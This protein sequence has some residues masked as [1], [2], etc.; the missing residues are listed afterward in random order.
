VL[1]EQ[2]R[3]R[4]RDRSRPL[5]AYAQ[6]VLDS[7]GLGFV[8]ELRTESIAGV[9]ERQLRGESCEALTE[10]A[11]LLI[12]VAADP[13]LAYEAPPPTHATPSSVVPAPLVPPA[14]SSPA[15]D[16]LPP[17]QTDDADLLPSPSAVE[18]APPPRSS[19]RAFV[20][21]ETTLQFFGLLPN[22][23]G[24]GFGGALGLLL[25]S[26][27]IELRGRYHLSSSAQ[28]PGHPEI[29][30]DF[31]QW[32]LGPSGCFE[33]AVG[34]VSFPLCGG[35]EVGATRGRSHGVTLDGRATSLF[36][37]LNADIAAVF[38]PIPQ[39]GFWLG[40]Q[41]VVA[42]SRPRFHIR[43]LDTLFRV[44]PGGL[45]LVAGIEVRFP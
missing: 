1:R 7:D 25:P 32:T 33:P 13:T 44:G 39:L 27:R 19:V 23:A 34:R 5:R 36:S 37:G 18:V 10:A 3:A 6:I 35:F 43:D 14:R 30:G 45:R 4:S 38:A 11:G 40:A 9:E 16:A 26:S 8:L 15:T 17:R 20:R 41:G 31:D 21:A 29:G 22:A 12:A 28:Y 42:L 2:V 24:L